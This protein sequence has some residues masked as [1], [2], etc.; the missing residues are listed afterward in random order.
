METG[1]L[2]G[3]AFGAYVLGLAFAFGW[4]PCLGPILG[5]ILGLHP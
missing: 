4:T 2:G 3:S 1:D 5:T